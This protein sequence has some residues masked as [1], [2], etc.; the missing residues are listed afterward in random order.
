VS[1]AGYQVCL[2]SGRSGERGSA[3]T[4]VLAGNGLFLDVQGPLLEAS[5]PIAPAQVRGLV[6]MEPRLFF[7]RGK[8]PSRFMDL[9]LGVLQASAHEKYLAIRGV[10]LDSYSLSEPEQEGREAGVQYSVLP[11]TV[12]NLHSHP[13]GLPAF[14]SGTDDSDDQGF[15]VSVVVANLDELFP[16]A[17]ARVCLYG[18]FWPVPLSWVFEGSVACIDAGLEPEEHRWHA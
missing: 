18:Y 12:V 14:F 9:A 3:Y 10:G 8:I 1:F 2:P 7:R 17:R 15:G 16:R 11:D 5:A 13:G 4:Y 6:E